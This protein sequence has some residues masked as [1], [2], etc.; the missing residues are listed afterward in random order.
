MYFPGNFHIFQKF[1][2]I[3]GGRL[4]GI[5]SGEGKTAAH[6]FCAKIFEKNAIFA[7]WPPCDHRGIF[8]KI[9]IF[10]KIVIYYWILLKFRDFLILSLRGASRSVGLLNVG[11]SFPGDPP[12]GGPSFILK[13]GVV[14]EGSL[15][16]RDSPPQNLL[17]EKVHFINGIFGGVPGYLGKNWEKMQKNVQFLRNFAQFYEIL[18]K[19]CKFLQKI[20]KNGYF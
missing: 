4:F 18:H 8:P 14:S 13:M 15:D 6:V 3:P 16:V 11:F 17:P 9:G 5:F 10:V 7:P 12:R 20:A 2:E 1:P 19:F